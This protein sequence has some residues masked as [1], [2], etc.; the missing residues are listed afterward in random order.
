[1][2]FYHASANLVYDLPVNGR[3]G[4]EINPNLRRSWHLCIL[5]IYT[6]QTGAEL[7]SLRPQLDVRTSLLKSFPIQEVDPEQAVGIA[8]GY[9]GPLP[10]EIPLDAHGL[11]LGA[12]QVGDIG[13]RDVARNLL[14]QR[15]ARGRQV[16]IRVE[17]RVDL[18]AARTEEAL[19]AVGELLGNGFPQQ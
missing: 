10:I 5:Y 2:A 16:V 13:Q 12:V 17:S 8:Y 14:L 11:R 1:D 3:G 15:Q 4:C 18:D 9:R 19:Q 6:I 7:S